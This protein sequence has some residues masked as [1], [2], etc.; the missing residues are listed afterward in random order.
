MKPS[1]IP[2]FIHLLQNFGPFEVVGEN[3]VASSRCHIGFYF[4]RYEDTMPLV[5]IGEAGKMPEMNLVLLLYL[6][7]VK[8]PKPSKEHVSD[9]SIIAWILTTYFADLLRG[10]F[11]IAKDYR[12][13]RERFFTLLSAVLDLPD[14]DPIRQKFEIFDLTWMRDL[15]RKQ[16]RGPIRFVERFLKLLVR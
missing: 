7:A 8:D 9:E 10:D 12:R 3:I 1:A 15:E 16:R 11:S 4:E 14:N 13:Y 2:H 6:R 5:L